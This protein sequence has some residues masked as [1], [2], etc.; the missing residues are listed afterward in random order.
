MLPILAGL[1]A[2]GS[3]TFGPPGEP[4]ASITLSG[5]V[6][7]KVGV[8]YPVVATLRTADGTVVDRPVTWGVPTPGKGVVSADGQFVASDTGAI[9]IR[10][11]VDGV[12]ATHHVV[13]YDW[14]ES[15][16]VVTT[17][18]RLDSD[19]TVANRHGVALQ[20]DLVVLCAAG[21]FYVV[22]IADAMEIAD[23]AVRYRFDNGAV[24][25]AEWLPASGAGAL[26]FPGTSNAAHKDFAA[27]IAASGT[28][29]FAFTEHAGDEH[30]LEFMVAGLAE[31]LGPL[32]AGCPV[33][34]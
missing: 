21:T 27:A 15:G 4:V 34:G 23:G 29:R 11:M 8:A 22:V 1:A 33:D 14:Q 5:P 31:R 12:T 13:G 3:I 24:H 9:V 2:C 6:R 10:A 32:L 20:P 28:F 7:A 30:E 16:D 18:L 19:N 25:D 17:V 26:I